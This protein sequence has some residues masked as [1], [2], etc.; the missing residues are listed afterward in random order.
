MRRE[1]IRIDEEKCD[2]CGDCVVA[3]EEGA[4]Q[5]IDGKARLVKDTYCDGLGACIGDCPQGALTIEVREA[6]DF[7]EEAVKQHLARLVANQM[8]SQA[9]PVPPVQP[10]APSAAPSGCPGSRPQAIRPPRPTMS[11]PCS[12]PASIERR[13]DSAAPSGSPAAG[14]LQST[15]GNWPIQ[16]HLMPVNAPYLQNARL[17]LA[18]DCVPFAYADFHRKLLDGRVVMVGCPKLDDAALYR[19]KLAEVFR[20]NDLQEVMIGVMEV[21]CC[22]GMVMLVRQAMLDSGKTIPINLTK[23]GVRGDVLETGTLQ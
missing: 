7:D 1:I 4:I 13:P 18:A 21:P 22:F 23:I 20:Q 15:L 8:Q 12:G 17:L 9:R 3:C 11:T 2:G 10:T 16:I 14:P 6:G 5:V 19:E